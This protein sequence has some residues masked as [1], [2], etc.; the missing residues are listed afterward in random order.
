MDIPYSAFTVIATGLFSGGAAWGAA[1]VAL[2]GTRQRV[3]ELE[4]SDRLTI[5]RLA[6]IET[7]I[8]LILE[9]R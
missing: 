5:E 9:K 2:N 4:E 3:K 6:R 1:K 7:K 8:D